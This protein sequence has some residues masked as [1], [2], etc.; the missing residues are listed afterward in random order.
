MAPGYVV[1]GGESEN[2]GPGPIWCVVYAVANVVLENSKSSGG[3]E[4][5]R[6]WYQSIELEELSKNMQDFFNK[7]LKLKILFIKTAKK[8]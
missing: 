4:T 3:I 5:N 2:R 8:R 7:K 6:N 1:G